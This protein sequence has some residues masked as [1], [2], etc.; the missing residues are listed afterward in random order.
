MA[1]NE[2]NVNRECTGDD[3]PLTG[4]ARSLA[5]LKKWQP[6]CPSPNPAGRAPRRRFI[7]ELGALLAEPVDAS[8]LNSK[9]KMRAVA[10]KLVELCLA[11]NVKAMAVFL[12]HIDP[13]RLRNAIRTTGNVN[14][15]SLGGTG[16]PES[17]RGIL[18]AELDQFIIDLPGVLKANGLPASALGPA[19]NAIAT[20]YGCISSKAGGALLRSQ[21]DAGAFPTRAGFE[22]PVSPVEDADV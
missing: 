16:D 10:E 18:R 21:L 22:L 6:G 5:N 2:E 13:Q 8:D 12:P 1:E 11:G 15:L 9:T 3:G 17:D 19:L 20:R 14:I 7:E 4:K